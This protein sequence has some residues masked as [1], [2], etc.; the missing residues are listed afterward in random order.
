MRGQGRDED[1]EFDGE[2]ED[3]EVDFLGGDGDDG[4]NLKYDDFFGSA[5]SEEEEGGDFGLEGSEEDEEEGEEA[6]GED[7][8]E[9]EAGEGELEPGM[10]E[11]LLDSESE[12]DGKPRERLTS[13]EKM[14]RQI[15][16][17]TKELEEKNIGPKVLP[18]LT[19][20][21]GV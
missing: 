8:E 5:G 6:E 12:E 3:G 2:D 9:E 18:T 17:K 20:R 4:Q 16:Q 15:A 11:D 13:F 7:E 19:L 1:E 21:T 14:Q 10:R